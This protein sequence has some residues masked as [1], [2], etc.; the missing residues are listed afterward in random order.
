MF[1]QR[2]SS[3]WQRA[4]GLCGPPQQLAMKQPRSRTDPM[5]QEDKLLMD[6]IS[7]HG[8]GNWSV[9]ARELPGRN[10]KSCRL[11]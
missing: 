4:A 8:T 1:E 11:R 9:I 3:I 6:L 7:R 10:G 5:A 2:R